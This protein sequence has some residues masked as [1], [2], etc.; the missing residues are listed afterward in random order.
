[1]PS[2]T[3]LQSVHRGFWEDSRP[4]IHQHEFT[5]TFF[6]ILL[7]EFFSMNS[8]SIQLKFVG[9]NSFLWTFCDTTLNSHEF[10]SGLGKKNSIYYTELLSYNIHACT[11]W[12][13]LHTC[14]SRRAASS[15]PST[16]YKAG[17]HEQYISTVPSSIQVFSFFPSRSNLMQ[18][19]IF[20]INVIV[21]VQ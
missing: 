6:W 3:S 8:I 16:K 13:S 1:M 21:L 15:I 10:S 11:Y 19:S 20:Y 17:H 12:I 14:R 9:V 7:C 18:L 4:W 2:C 5:Q